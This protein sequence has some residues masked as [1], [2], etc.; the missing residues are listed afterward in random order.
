MKIVLKDGKTIFT[1]SP[2]RFDY[3]LAYLH[4]IPSGEI[5]LV[6]IKLDKVDYI[7]AL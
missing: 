6:P 1:S 7:E 3:S 5:H 4:C 2:I